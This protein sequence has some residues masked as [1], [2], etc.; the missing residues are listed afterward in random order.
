VIAA[1]LCVRV[2][3]RLERAQAAGTKPRRLPETT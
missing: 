1:V 3:D 2:L